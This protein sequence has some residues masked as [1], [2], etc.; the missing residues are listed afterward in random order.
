VFSVDRKYFPLTNFPNGKQT[1]ESLENGFLET[2]F[3]ETNTALNLNNSSNFGQVW[4]STSN[5]LSIKSF[6]IPSCQNIPT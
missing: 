1:H 5:F 6:F 3:R 4:I 2:S